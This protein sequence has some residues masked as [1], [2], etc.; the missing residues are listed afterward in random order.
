MPKKYCIKN[1]NM[2]HYKKKGSEKMINVRE[3][4]LKKIFNLKE[5]L[6][7]KARR[8]RQYREY[9]EEAIR[10]GEADIEAG[11]VEPLDKVLWE[12]E[13]EFGLKHYE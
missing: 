6:T 12:I 2:L 4:K 1:G 9:V 11:R 7:E 13:E 8:D 10:R 5:Y 3:L